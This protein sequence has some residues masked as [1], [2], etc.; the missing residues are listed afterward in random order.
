MNAIMS[1]MGVSL[2]NPID[3]GAI[4]ARGTYSHGLRLVSID[5]SLLEGNQMAQAFRT[6]RHEVRHAYQYYAVENPGNFTVSGATS[7]A[8]QA[9][10]PPRGR[11]R[12]MSD[13]Y[14]WEE[15]NVQPI[16]LDAFSFASFREWS[17]GE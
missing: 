17:P 9:N 16:E 11:Y 12:R 5:L 13:G 7:E 3:F 10:L 4:G 8:W 6:L 2:D 1:I 15:Y 14:T